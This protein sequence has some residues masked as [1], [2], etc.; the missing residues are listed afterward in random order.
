MSMKSGFP[1]QAF[2]DQGRLVPVA[3]TFHTLTGGVTFTLPWFNR[4]QGAVRAATADETAA[5]RQLDRVRLAA[6][7]QVAVG[8]VQ[9]EKTGAAA[10]V[11]RDEALTR[12]RA[13]VEVVKEAYALGSRTLSD[14]L[15]E[16]RRLQQ[17]EVEYTD[18]LRDWYQAGVALRAALGEIDW[19]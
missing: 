18:A 7:H 8:R 17:I 14:V 16:T 15:A 10:A 13:N 11:L 6:E 9:V 3:A 5:A 19:Q 4:Q 12:A 1:Q 2:S